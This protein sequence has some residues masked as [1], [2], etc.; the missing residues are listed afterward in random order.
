M[1]ETLLDAWTVTQKELRELM[2]TRGRSPGGIF[3]VAAVITLLGIVL[4]L[5]A[6]P[7][8][9]DNT[10]L[11]SL[12]AWVPVFIVAT[13]V[14]D[15]VAG[16]RERHTL[17]TLMASPLPDRAILLGKISAAVIYGWGLMLITIITSI[18]AI[19]IVYAR[20]QLLLYRPTLLISGALLSL[21]TSI[22][23]ASFGVL[24]SL[25][26]RSV[27][28]AQRIIMFTLAAIFTLHIVAA[29][30]ATH[31]M[32][33]AGHITL[34]SLYLVA[35]IALVLVV[36]NFVLLRTAMHWFHRCRLQ[37]VSR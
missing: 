16:E 32:P 1:K 33:N 17:E 22:L 24:V 11:L 36:I 6:G 25:R 21:L 8:W 3:L 12:W 13:V 4:P 23:A 35:A 5:Q 27:R 28:Q 19:N 29:P 14:A 10:W 15:S 7:Q 18:A 9:L 37:M 30:L 34:E 20:E 26:A 2:A 31:F